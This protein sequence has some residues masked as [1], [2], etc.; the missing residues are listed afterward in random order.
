[1]NK[2]TKQSENISKMAMR[3]SSPL[4]YPFPKHPKNENTRSRARACSTRAP[5]MNEP[6]AEEN[7]TMKMP[8][9]AMYGENPT[10]WKT[11][12]FCTSV[13]CVN[14]NAESV[15]SSV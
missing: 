7:P 2:Q 5:P 11:F 10:S 9:T 14:T 13:S 15:Y 1:M 4:P 6:S 8:T 3:G 12:V